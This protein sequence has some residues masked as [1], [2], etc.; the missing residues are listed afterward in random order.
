MKKIIAAIL[1]LTVFLSLAFAQ[2]DVVLATVNG[3]PI[4][5]SQADSIM[6]AL[7]NF[8][9]IESEAD[10]DSVVDFLVQEQLIKEKIVEMKFDVFSEEEMNAFL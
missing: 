10:Y 7:V 1:A 3:T 2:E 8:N 9:Y 4:L 5:K 6:P